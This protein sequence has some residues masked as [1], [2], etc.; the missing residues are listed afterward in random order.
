M[1]HIYDNYNS[2]LGNNEGDFVVNRIQWLDFNL[3]SMNEN[4][5]HEPLREA[6]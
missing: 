6:R 4:H 3:L 1:E 5:I 2:D